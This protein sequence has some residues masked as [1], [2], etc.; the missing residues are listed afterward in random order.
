MRI[1]RANRVEVL[2]VISKRL[3]VPD[4]WEREELLEAYQ[5][6]MEENPLTTFVLLAVEDDQV[7]AFFIASAPARG[8]HVRLWQA[9]GEPK[10]PNGVMD[11]M[12]H[13]LMLWVEEMGHT[14]V[15][16][17][18]KRHHD[19][20]TRKWGFQLV[21]YNMVFD[22]EGNY[23][24]IVTRA[25]R[26]A[27]KEINDG[28]Q[29]PGTGTVSD[30]DPSSAFAGE[31]DLQEPRGTSSGSSGADETP[32]EAT[33]DGSEPRDAAGSGVGPDEDSGG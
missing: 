17:E 20:M 22:V 18:T 16:I 21:S 4:G 33:P 13:Q 5:G 11:R 29:R 23:S 24:K 7:R 30:E 26:R 3:I 14:G 8:K 10:L 6:E 12:F 25:Q 2:N 9:W 15:K 19:V 1:F 28:R 27:I 31:G 32:N